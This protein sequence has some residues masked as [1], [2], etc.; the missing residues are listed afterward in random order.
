MNDG[1]KHME[2][3][4]ARIS[5][6]VLIEI[7]HG[8]KDIIVELINHAFPREGYLEEGRDDE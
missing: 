6:A 1:G 7:V 4:Q 3:K 8:I 5:D 2:G